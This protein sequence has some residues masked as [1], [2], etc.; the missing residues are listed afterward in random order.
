MAGFG[1]TAPS[2]NA[3]A[4][5][6]AAVERASVT[7]KRSVQ[8]VA[9][10]VNVR[11][12]ERLATSPVDEVAD[13]RGSGETGHLGRERERAGRRRGEG[14]RHISEVAARARQESLAAGE[15][16]ARAHRRDERVGLGRGRQLRGVVGVPAGR[17]TVEELDAR[18]PVVDLTGRRRA[19]ETQREAGR[20]SRAADKERVGRGP[21]RSEVGEGGRRATRGLGEDA[22]PRR[23]A[24]RG[25]ARNDLVRVRC[26]VKR[27]ERGLESAPRSV[28]PRH[29]V[30]RHGLRERVADHVETRRVQRER[31]RVVRRDRRAGHTERTGRNAV[32]LAR[33]TAERGVSRVNVLIIDLPEEPA[34]RCDLVNNIGSRD[35]GV[36]DIGEVKIVSSPRVL[37]SYTLDEVDPRECTNRDTS[38]GSRKEPVAGHI[39]ERLHDGHLPRGRARRREPEIVDGQTVIVSSI[40]DVHPTNPDLASNRDNRADRSRTERAVSSCVSVERCS[41]VVAIGDTKS[42]ASTSE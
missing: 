15:P 22:L 8:S 9:S 25:G 41:R 19:V 36:V 23:E 37:P 18:R 14:E 35:V 40:I 2:E 33:T 24:P 32:A 1:E 27:L 38:N 4:G 30:G 16:V 28:G 20:R 21:A 10:D 13:G 7:T 11:P 42:S 6:S 29:A 17:G 12:S 39:V 34:A 5:A 3:A 26:G 31:L